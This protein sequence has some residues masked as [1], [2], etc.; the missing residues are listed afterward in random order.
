MADKINEIAH[1]MKYGGQAEVIEYFHAEKENMEDTWPAFIDRM[2]DRAGMKRT[3]IAY[4]TGLSRD[5]LYKLLR[6]DKKTGERDYIIAICFALHMSETETQH[7]LSIYPLPPLDEYDGRSSIILSALRERLTLNKVNTWLDKAGYPQIKISPDMESAK[8]QKY[9]SPVS[10]QLKET[11][12]KKKPE[13][14]EAEFDEDD[15]CPDEDDKEKELKISPFFG[16][17]MRLEEDKP[18]TFAVRCGDAPFDYAYFGEV[19]VTDLNDNQVYYAQ[20]IFDPIFTAFQLTAESMFGADGRLSKRDKPLAVYENYSCLDEAGTSPFFKYYLEVDKATDKKVIEVMNTVDDTKYYRGALRYGSGWHTKPKIYIEMFNTTQPEYS[21]YLQVTKYGDGSIRYT[22]SHTSAFMQIEL[23]T[24][25][26]A[27]WPNKEKVKY[28]IDINDLKDLDE[29]YS[30]FYDTYRQLQTRLT[31]MAKEY[32]GLIEIEDDDPDLTEDELKKKK[33]IDLRAMYEPRE[34][35]VADAI[36]EIRFIDAFGNER[37]IEVFDADDDLICCLEEKSLYD[38]YLGISEEKV[39]LTIIELY[40]SLEETQRDG[41][42]RMYKVAA[43]ARE[44]A[45]KNKC[46]YEWR[47]GQPEM[48]NE[49]YMLDLERI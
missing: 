35:T 20:G 36:A 12:N 19:K 34:E 49:S 6:G 23:G 9:S 38:V 39:G 43:E 5:Y 8:V 24:I 7:A 4:S 47:P 16:I 33:I 3:E 2:I 30:Y 27:Y 44:Y 25:Y 32:G 41:Y 17:K 26:D 21:E 10:V 31:R 13:L 14:H 42:R 11:V 29:K 48:F 45:L 1:L 40:K 37:C 22:A 28:Y 15:W 18:N 46:T